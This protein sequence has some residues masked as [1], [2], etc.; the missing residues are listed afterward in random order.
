MSDNGFSKVERNRFLYLRVTVRCPLKEPNLLI[1]PGLGHLNRQT[2]DHGISFP[3]V[4]R[5]I[6]GSQSLPLSGDRYIR[7][8]GASK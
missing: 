2:H 7:V 1:Q 5:G 8:E 3:F 6:R 4:L